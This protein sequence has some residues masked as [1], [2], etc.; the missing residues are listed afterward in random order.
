MYRPKIKKDQ[1]DALYILSKHFN[2][3]MTKVLRGAIA[4]Y[5]KRHAKMLQT[6]KENER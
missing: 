2:L 4:Q 1:L 3:P 6:I 5:L